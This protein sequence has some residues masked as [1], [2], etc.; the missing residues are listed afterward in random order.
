MSNKNTIMGENEGSDGS[1]LVELVGIGS[2]RLAD[3]VLRKEI[4]W[5]LRSPCFVAQRFFSSVGGLSLSL[6]LSHTFFTFSE[7]YRG[8]LA[9]END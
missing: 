6:S 9:T 2:C 1:G 4:S 8:M 5:V 3:G 7:N